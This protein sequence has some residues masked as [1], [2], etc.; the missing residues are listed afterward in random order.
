M[1]M[2]YYNEWWNNLGIFSHFTSHT[3]HTGVHMDADINVADIVV[4]QQ[5]EP[6]DL[7][8]SVTTLDE[9]VAMTIVRIIPWK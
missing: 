1:G 6:Q 5:D 9:P 7:T 3:Q 4:E 8:D 2:V